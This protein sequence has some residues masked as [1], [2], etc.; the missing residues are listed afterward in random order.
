MMRDWE[1]CN[2]F[3]LLHK[4][5]LHRSLQPGLVTISSLDVGYFDAAGG[6]RAGGYGFGSQQSGDA[7]F[8]PG[9]SQRS[10]REPDS[11]CEGV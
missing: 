9:S 1:K 8:Q 11:G 10:H 4:R 7:G 3:D 6:K 2:L 5:A